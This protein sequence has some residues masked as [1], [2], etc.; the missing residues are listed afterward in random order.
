MAARL[1]RTG[2]L[3][4]AGVTAPGGGETLSVLLNLGLDPEDVKHALPRLDVIP[5]ESEQRFMAT[6]HR[7]NSS[8][9]AYVKGA[10][11]TVIDL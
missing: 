3:V 4:L 8:A 5:F 7:Q 9:V 11:E 1:A 2:H 10:P 6:L